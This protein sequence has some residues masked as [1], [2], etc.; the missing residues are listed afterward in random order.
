M[1]VKQAKI[2]GERKLR[3]HHIAIWRESPLFTPKERA[4]LAWTER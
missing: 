1:H 3:L 2:R 4:A